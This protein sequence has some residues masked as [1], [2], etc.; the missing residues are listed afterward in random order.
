MP[1]WHA[2]AKF[3]RKV[4]EARR[5][6]AFSR[7]DQICFFRGHSNSQYRL[8]PSL[9]RVRLPN[10]RQGEKREDA[11]WKLERRLFFEFRGGA[12]ELYT[13]DSTDW[14]VLF[15]MQHHGVPTRLLDWTS[16]FG[17]A[18]YFAL[19]NYRPKQGLSPCVWLLNPYALNNA[20]WPPKPGRPA[21][22]RLYHPK[23]IALSRFTNQ[24]YDFGDLL[25][26]MHPKRWGKQRLSWKTPLAIY[27]YQRSERMY[28]QEG[29]FTIH[30]TNIAPLEDMFMQRPRAMQ[31]ILQR[32]DIPKDA[33]PALQ[34][35]LA[36]AGI[37]PR[38][39]FP[40]LSGLADSIKE[41]FEIPR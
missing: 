24:P 32:V 10:L 20:T 26:G 35:F 13:T 31:S 8:L 6:L 21:R 30:G 28:A 19:L 14:D 2:F 17:V 34:R 4:E 22:Y 18:L 27:P 11:Y 40:D 29:W 15:H 36:D 39:L 25:L 41:R 9:F 12:R 1:D 5:N 37:G 7:K 16:V 23:Y 3:M 38:Q 33:I